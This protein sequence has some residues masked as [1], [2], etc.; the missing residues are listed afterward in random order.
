MYTVSEAWKAVQAQRLVN[1]GY[2]E[3]TF[4]VGDPEA[5]SDMTASDNGHVYISDVAGT[6][7][8]VRR[9][10]AK[11][12][13]LERDAWKCDGGFL[14]APRDVPD[15]MAEIKYAGYTGA[16]LSGAD[17]TF[18][19]QPVLT[20]N[21][22][23]VHAPLIPGVTIT[24]S[25]ARGEYA[26]DFTITAYN[27]QAQVAQKA[28]TG[29][30]LTMSAIWLDIAGY[31][32]IEIA[33]HKWSRAYH[34]ARAEKLLAGIT[35]LYGKR[36]ITSYSHEASMSPI[37]AELP[38]DTMV[39]ALDNSAQVYDP[40][41]PTGM[42][43]YLIERQELQARYGLRLSDGTTEWIPAGTFYLSEWDAP[44]N[45]IEASFTGR[46]IT[47]LLQ[48]TY[49]KGIYSAAGQTLY[50]LAY[51]VLEGA[52]L[53]LSADGTPRWEL[54]DALKA[55]STTAPLPVATRAECLQM[56]AQAGCMEMW[57]DRLGKLHIGPG[58]AQETDYE[59]NDF[60]L[61]QR[62]EI[63]LLKPLKDISVN[64]YEYFPDSAGGQQLYT[65]SVNV[66][67]TL[68]V[69]L[70]YSTAAA[71]ATAVVSGGTLDAASYYASACELTI[72]GSGTVTITIT[73]TPLKSSTYAHVLTYGTE[74]E[75]QEVDNPLITSG[76]Q[77]DAVA[78]WAGAYLTARRQLTAQDWRADP[79]L[80]PGDTVT[81]TN[82]YGA[83]QAR[84]T[85]VKYQF[86]GA[87]HASGEAHVM[88]GGGA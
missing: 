41:N 61:Y 70:T 12:A 29:N 55:I 57:H 39:F 26:E 15:E 78:A 35:V 68:K 7:D 69:T 59:L 82:R 47:A 23:T 80:D 45:G 37:G 14:F 81:V 24:W 54:D 13:T 6:A 34:Y 16:A 4:S 9:A 84:M 88:E 76:A 11:Y 28:V 18:A 53:P 64:T 10:A 74:G 67:G 31:D 44:Q 49:A 85:R 40:N 87:F 79:R 50:A 43:R 20:M 72:T 58:S 66:N 62:P 1:E 56:I 48:G 19:A 21:F 52:G 73:G 51:E 2:I 36:D 32:R 60:V 8:T 5:W 22:S 46:D 25:D 3:I 27:G 77:A 86:T 63:S 71:D 65:G 83:E 30:T 42:S 38:K 75:T 17:G 33:I